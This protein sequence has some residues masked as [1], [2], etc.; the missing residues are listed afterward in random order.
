M[1]HKIETTD[2]PKPEPKAANIPST[3]SSTNPSRDPSKKRD[4]WQENPLRTP[5]FTKSLSIEGAITAK[6]GQPRES[7]RPVVSAVGQEAVRHLTCWN[8]FTRK[9]AILM[10]I[11]LIVATVHF[12]ALRQYTRNFTNSRELHFVLFYGGS[13]AL[14]LGMFFYFLI[15]HKRLAADWVYRH[16]TEGYRKSNVESFKRSTVRSS[17]IPES[18]RPPRKA[19]RR[20]RPSGTVAK[21]E[22]IVRVV[23][24]VYSKFT[25]LKQD[26]FSVNGK[27]HL[28]KLSIQE[29]LE[30][31]WQ[32]Y[33]LIDMHLCN[34]P[35][36]GSS[37]LV[38]FL[39]C[40]SA[41][42]AFLFRKYLCKGSEYQLVS[43]KQRDRQ[44][45]T[46]LVVD[47]LLL[48]VPLAMYN[49]VYRLQ[50]THLEVGKLLII[51]TMC[52]ITKNHE[53]LTALIGVNAEAIVESLQHK[54]ER[55]SKKR[56]SSFFTRLTYTQDIVDKQN[57]TF[58]RLAKAAVC[59]ISSVYA[60]FLFAM[61]MVQ[62]GLLAGIEERCVGYFQGMWNAC[63]LRVYYCN[64]A[65]EPSCNC[66]KFEKNRHNW[67]ILPDKIEELTALKTL[68]L[69]DGPLTHLPEKRVEKLRKLSQLDFEFNRL[70]AFEVNVGELNHLITINLGYNE[71]NALHA[72][73]WSH[74]ELV[75]V[76]LN[77]N[78]NVSIPDTGVYMPSLLRLLMQN[79][80]GA[81]PEEL[82]KAQFPS[83]LE[84]Y[85]SGNVGFGKRIPRSFETLDLQILD[86]ARCGISGALP[87]YF[88]D[89][90]AKSLYR[91][92]A[93]DNNLTSVDKALV[94]SVRGDVYLS[95]NP[96]CDG[97]SDEEIVRICKPLCSKFCY[98]RETQKNFCDKSCNSEACKYDSGDCIG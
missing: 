56:K 1:D 67:T 19:P 64:N 24:F 96:L 63:T 59:I 12:I 45:V 11:Q 58:P 70:Q 30:D 71:I 55:K 62:V 18:K 3:S 74:P 78:G 57:K 6:R 98:K 22:T 31:W 27:Y 89:T 76:L 2:G 61:L 29:A 65:F 17:V 46:D 88:D 48:I 86:I 37:L 54:G 8:T 68:S 40:E 82:G 21:V 49:F 23:S 79:N 32:L 44:I 26:W 72:S 34:L 20:G 13:C 87:R 69:T 15:F 51:P 35:I 83:P 53:L 80:T 33:T 9:G 42:R 97:A 4:E 91:L 5:T 92:D 16:A 14:Y 28:L 93:R 47:V 41:Y 94:Q 85:I 60:C 43:M 10:I 52:L 95:G 39:V 66:V 81:F 50:I 38:L 77:S 75:N 7:A 84:L 36:L 25:T 73:I 90:L